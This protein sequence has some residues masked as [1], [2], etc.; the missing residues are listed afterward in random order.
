MAIVLICLTP[1]IQDPFEFF[2]AANSLGHD[3]AHVLVAPVGHVNVGDFESFTHRLDGSENGQSDG[4]HDDRSTI[5][6]PDRSF[7]PRFRPSR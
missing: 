5:T 2:K 7:F 3:A 1:F 4:I 6:S